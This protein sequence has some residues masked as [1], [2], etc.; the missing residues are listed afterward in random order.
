MREAVERHGGAIENYVGDAVM[1]GL[2]YPGAHEDDA[3][4]AVAGGGGDAG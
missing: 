2:R 4:R 3:L 1:A